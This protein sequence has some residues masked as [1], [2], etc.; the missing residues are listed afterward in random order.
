MISLIDICQ[1][2]VTGNLFSDNDIL[3]MFTT[4]YTSGKK[5]TMITRNTIKMDERIQ[6]G[7]PICYDKLDQDNTR[8]I[9]CNSGKHV[10]CT[11]CCLKYFREYSNCPYCRENL[12]DFYWIYSFSF[13]KNFLK[14]YPDINV[15]DEFG[16]PALIHCIQN[17][18]INIFKI[19]LDMN[20]DVNVKDANGDYAIHHAYWAYYEFVV[21][22]EY[23]EFE[24]LPMI[25]DKYPDI[26]VKNGNGE[27]IL[28]QAICNNDC[29]W[30]SRLCDLDTDFNVPDLNGDTPLGLIARFR[31]TTLSSYIIMKADDL[32]LGNINNGNSPIQMMI[33]RNNNENAI[34]N[35]IGEMKEYRNYGYRIH[36]NRLGQTDLHFCVIYRKIFYLNFFLKNY[37]KW[38]EESELP[39]LSEYLEIKDNL[40]RTPL[41]VACEFGYLEGVLLL[42]NN[43]ADINT[44]DNEGRDLVKV[45]EENNHACVVYFLN[46]KKN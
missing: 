34:E 11:G 18:R 16:C 14:K 7:C 6:E 37:L 36:R 15:V 28:H 20:A 43:G 2:G 22:E 39:E 8:I 24:F 30:V 4:E 3:T 9:K 29:E 13:F 12:Y 42:L 26:N 21:E 27:T 41:F 35:F 10:L 32:Y 46:L 44:R 1:N 5:H 40:G 45:A 31:F 25:L 23:P 38:R 17:N 19:L 33:A